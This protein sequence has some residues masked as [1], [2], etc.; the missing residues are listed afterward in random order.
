[1]KSYFNKRKQVIDVDLP[2]LNK[3]SQ[4]LARQVKMSGYEPE[5]VLYVER[6][7]LLVGFEM[8][9][10]LNCTISGIHSKRTGGSAKSSIKH[11]LRWLPRFVTH[12]LRKLELSSNIHHLKNKRQIFCEQEMPPSEKRLLLVDDAIDTGHSIVAILDFLTG[13]GY[14][15]EN[16]RIAVLT[17]TGENPV[18]RADYSLL[19]HVVCAFPWSYDSRHYDR[20]EGVY[21]TEK[22]I[23]NNYRL[24]PRHEINSNEP[25]PTIA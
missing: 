12:F 5:H 13:R 9:L 18:I 23:V 6:A 1:M 14:K 17:T 25:N 10:F 15:R 21:H 22:Y 16:I 7:G 24:L 8:A 11:I 19:H 3:M 20:T 2:L 4:D